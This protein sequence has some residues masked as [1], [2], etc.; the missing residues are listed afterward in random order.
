MNPVAG[1]LISLAAGTVL[2]VGPAD[3][4][5]VAADAGFPATGIWFDPSTWTD[6][7]TKEVAARLS[8]TGVVALD[9]EPVI[10]G[11]G[12]DPGDRLVD[13]A[14]QLGAGHVLV[15]SGP[16]DRSEVLDRFASL[17]DRAAP[18][19][20]AI[21]LEFLPIFTVGS[22]A[23]AIEIV[24]EAGRPNA[25]VL[26]DTLHLARS[27]GTA[28]DLRAVPPRLLPYLQLADAP[29]AAPPQEQLRDEALHGRRLPGDGALP[30]AA[31]LDAVPAVPVSLE[32]RSRAAM[33]AYPDPTDRARAV[34]AA[35]QQLLI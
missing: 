12:P 16:A 29:A 9:I 15:A 11:R 2:D 22:L 33:E 23:A 10:L 35:T 5:S 17:C 4:V 32:I 31:V 26:V 27:G 28:A 34:L 3:T 21:V 6:A 13:T 18:A 14:A 20:V 7:T 8:D 1:R 19:G 30:L 24:Q 25:G